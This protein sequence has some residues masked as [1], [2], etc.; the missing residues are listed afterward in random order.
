MYKAF[1]TTDFDIEG[2]GK[3]IAFGQ[4]TAC[5]FHLMRVMEVGLRVLGDALNLPSTSNRNWDDILNKADKEV[6]TRRT[7]QSPEWQADEVFFSSAVAHLRSVKTAWRNPTMHIEAKYTE[8]EAE[9]IWNHVA[10]FMRHLSTR[11]SGV[12]D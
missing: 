11:L 2:A 1:P 6:K 7:D 9:D 3:C 8:E 10:S 5:V 12:T 4:G